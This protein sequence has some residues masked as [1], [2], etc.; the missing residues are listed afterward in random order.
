MSLAHPSSSP[1]NAAGSLLNGEPAFL[2]VGKLRHAHGVHGEILMEVYTDFPERLQPGTILFLEAGTA[3]LTVS[4]RR[5][6][7]QGLLLTFQGYATPEA[8]SQLR[9]QLLYVK[10]EDRP[11]LEQGEYY[12]HQLIGLEAVSDAGEAIGVVR[13]ILET[14][15]SDVLVIRPDAGPEVLIPM[16][17]EFVR[18]IDLTARQIT[19]HLIPGM[20]AEEF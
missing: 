6:H 10:A 2:A 11:P 7:H 20:R 17:G 15:A 8:V 13:D 3:Q 9:N 1:V 14:G 18:R 19:V 5:N 4:K 12:H 16:V